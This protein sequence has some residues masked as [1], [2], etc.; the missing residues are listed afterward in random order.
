[1][2]NSD[3]DFMSN[4]SQ[5]FNSG[6]QGI[7]DIP[8]L[9]VEASKNEWSEDED[10]YKRFL[11]RKFKFENH[12]HLR[13]FVSEVLK[14]SDKMS[15]HPSLLITHDEVDVEIYTHDINDISERD[16][17][18]AKFIDEIYDDVKFMLEY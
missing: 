2:T 8:E 3:A 15:H 12:R 7:R 4:M 5:L 10:F 14:E 6:A 11:K 16:L 17:K 9:P 13:Y 1:M 18:L